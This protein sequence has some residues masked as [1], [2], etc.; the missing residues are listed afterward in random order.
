MLEEDVATG[1]AAGRKA[2]GEAHQAHV[3]NENKAGAPVWSLLRSAGHW[4]TR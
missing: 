3:A 1:H 2:P 4:H